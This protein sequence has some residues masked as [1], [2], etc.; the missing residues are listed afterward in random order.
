MVLFA[1]SE[2]FSSN[3]MSPE[4]FVLTPVICLH[5]VK[6]F[7]GSICTIDRSLSC[8][9][10]PGQRGPKSKDNKRVLHFLQSSKSGAL[11]TEGL[12]S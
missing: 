8:A 7:N 9:T 3:A 11:P 5:R 6:Y 1:H 12:A 4:Q 2:M 10:P